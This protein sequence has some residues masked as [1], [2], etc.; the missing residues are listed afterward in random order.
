[1]NR[2]ENAFKNGK[3]LIPFLTGG[4]PNVDVTYEL[5]KVMAENGADVI[6]LGIP[7]SDPV[8]EGPAVQEA[9]LRALAAKTTTDSIFDMVERLRKEIDIPIVL[10]TYMNPIYVYGIKRFMEKCAQVGVDGVMVPDVPYEE[11]SELEIDCK[12]NGVCLISMTSLTTKDRIGM[13]SKEA[14]GYVYCIST[15]GALENVDKV[16]NDIADMAQLV[17]EATDV[18]VVVG[19]DGSNVSDAVAISEVPDGIVLENAIVNLVAQYGED[20]ISHV[21]DFVKKLKTGMIR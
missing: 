4:D 9:D 2:I 10:L 18:P 13:I 20:A 12:E 11:K 17:N 6:E 16:K 3:V 8:A 19:F 1:M 14:E 21:A 5:I 15:I 7:F